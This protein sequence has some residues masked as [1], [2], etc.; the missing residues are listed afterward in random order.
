M[1]DAIGGRGITPV[2]PI[3]LHKA[4]QLAHIEIFPVTLARQG[5][6]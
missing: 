1:P 4:C 3:D 2:G 6:S 5:L